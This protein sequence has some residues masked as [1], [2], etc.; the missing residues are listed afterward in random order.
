MMF[1]EIEF[2]NKEFLIFTFALFVSLVL[3][4]LITFNFYFPGNIITMPL[5][6]GMLFAW[7]YSSAVLKDISASRKDFSFKFLLSHFH[8]F[9][10]YSLLLLTVYA[11]FNFFNTFSLYSDENWLDLDLD[12]NKLRGISGFWIVFYMLGLFGSIL[13]VKFNTDQ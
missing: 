9:I 13:K 3:H 7:L 11:I 1:G 2:L 8:P 10:K 4:I 6:G 5:T 12:Y